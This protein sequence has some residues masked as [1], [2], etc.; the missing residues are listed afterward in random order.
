[1]G[2]L[3]QTLL[4][5]GDI[6]NDSQS[7]LANDENKGFAKISDTYYHYQ[8]NLTAQAKTD[9]D[10][11]GEYLPQETLPETIQSWLAKKELTG[12]TGYPSKSECKGLVVHSACSG[13]RG[14]GVLVVST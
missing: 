4:R 10:L 13:H 8:R 5:Y 12:K 2:C 1:M 14:L 7:E 6:E 9:A 11:T 3:T